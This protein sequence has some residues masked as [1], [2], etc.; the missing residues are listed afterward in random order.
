LTIGRWKKRP[1]VSGSRKTI[2]K[3]KPVS[4]VKRTKEREPID[5]NLWALFHMISKSSAMENIV[6]AM[7]TEGY[8]LTSREKILIRSL[9]DIIYQVPLAF[10][11]D[12]FKPGDVVV[13]YTN[14]STFTG[15]SIDLGTRYEEGYLLCTD[16][17]S[18]RNVRKILVEDILFLVEI[19]TTEHDVSFLIK[20][21]NEQF[22]V[23]VG[24]LAISK[25]ERI[26]KISNILLDI[27]KI[28]RDNHGNYKAFL[29]AVHTKL[30]A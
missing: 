12:S 18:M 11:V 20:K 26:Q 5:K 22:R 9:I 19:C 30:S 10:R 17:E 2:I 14:N 13:S 25:D 6:G 8:V 23:F 27:R 24:G 4:P 3:R 1:M 29:V 28:I 21:C 7:S 16:I 15:R